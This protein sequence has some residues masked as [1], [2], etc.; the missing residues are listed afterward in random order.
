MEGGEDQNRKSPY[1]AIVTHGATAKK[2]YFPIC[3]GTIG[4][5][6]LWNEEGEER[7]RRWR[8]EEDDEEGEERREGRRGEDEEEERRGRKA[9][10]R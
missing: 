10:K 4:H 2:K 3:D 9:M 7:G 1:M 5:H 8:R 6:S